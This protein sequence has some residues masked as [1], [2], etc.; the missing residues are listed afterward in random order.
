MTPSQ[1]SSQLYELLDALVQAT[2]TPEQHEQLQGMLRADPAARAKYFDYIDLDIGLEQL[3]ATGEPPV[4]SLPTSQLGSLPPP[5]SGWQGKA[6][7]LAALAAALLLAVALPVLWMNWLR[8]AHTLAHTAAPMADDQAASHRPADAVLLAQA[9]G[10]QLFGETLPAV[11][12]T[13]EPQHEYALIAGMFELHFPSGAEVIIEAPSVVK[14]LGPEQ[15]MMIAGACSVHAPPGAE[16]FQVHTPQTEIV[17]LG[18]RFNVAVSELGETDVQVVSGLAEVRGTSGKA[19]DPIRL[20]ERQARRFVGGAEEAPQALPYKADAYRGQLPDRVMSYTAQ[21]NEQGYVSELTSVTVQRGGQVHTYRLDD[22]IGVRMLHFRAGENSNNLLVSTGWKG[23]RLAVIEDDALL[24]TGFINPGGAKRPLRGSPV[25][26]RSPAEADDSTPGMAV[27]FT[28]PVINGPGPDVVFFDLQCVM[29]PPQG[30]A[31][32]V[33]PLNMAAG[34]HAATVHTYDITM[35]S[36]EA[37]PLVRFDQYFYES[38]VRSLEALLDGDIR[39]RKPALRFSA[40]AVGIDLSSLGYAPHAAVDGLFFQD[41]LDDSD[42]V[43]PVFIA[44]FPPVK[45]ATP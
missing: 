27:R 7:T 35:T 44:G 18:T 9:A 10:A 21:A 33:S 40:L 26:A 5:G 28:H 6:L 38:Q 1:A 43:D 25:L 17:D 31:F 45:E 8:D 2:I 15:L 37:R 13:L 36:P 29:N 41:A 30:D 32:H 4:P 22:L 14:I 34:L 3:M 23:A 42:M 12:T 24:H 19:S 20:A 11:G 39:L 16:G